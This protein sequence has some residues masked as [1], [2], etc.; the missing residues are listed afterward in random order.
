[1]AGSKRG[2]MRSLK[3]PGSIRREH[4]RYIALE[5]MIGIAINAILSMGLAYVMFEAHVPIPGD[6]AALLR[7]IGTQCFI[8]A[9]ASVLLPTLLTRRRCRRGTIRGL[10]RRSGWFD[11]LLLRALLIAALA[12]VMAV[13]LLYWAV[14]PQLAPPRLTI[15][16]YLNLK[17]IV[18]GLVALAVTPIAVHWALG[19]TMPI[20][21]HT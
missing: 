16:V 9:L 14:L 2:E 17:G 7:D 12:T 8:V 21:S 19:D 10:E 20:G 4:V 11:I 13:T 15:N 5:T 1:V 3:L 18:G 6:G